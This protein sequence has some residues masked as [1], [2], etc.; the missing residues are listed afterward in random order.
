ML[1]VRT[2]LIKTIIKISLIFSQ[3]SAENGVYTRAK[4]QSAPSTP[5]KP[6]DLSLVVHGPGGLPRKLPNL[7]H[8]LKWDATT[9]TVCWE[10]QLRCPLLTTWP[11][12]IFVTKKKK[13]VLGY[14]APGTIIKIR[15]MVRHLKLGDHVVIELVECSARNRWI[16]HCTVCCDPSSSVPHWQVNGIHVGSTSRVLNSAR[17]FLTGI[18]MEGALTE[19]FSVKIIAWLGGEFTLGI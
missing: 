15:V 14:E 10:P 6:E 9:G 4:E 3:G 2:S 1:D 16:L 5:A 19:P 17:S 7:R 12:W 13:M 18:F 11:K 8:R